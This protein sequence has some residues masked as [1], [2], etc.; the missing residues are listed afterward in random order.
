[1]QRI[2]TIL[3]FIITTTGFSQG[4]ITYK[5]ANTQ[6]YEAILN[7]DWDQ[8]ISL[9]KEA[10]ENGHDFFYLNLRLGIAF[11]RKA[12]Y[13]RAKASLREAYI[14][15]A[16]DTTLL[17]YSS[18]NSLALGESKL[19]EFYAEKISVEKKKLKSISVTGGLKKINIKE[20]GSN[21]YHLNL[22]GNLQLNA[23]LNSKINLTRITQKV[24]WGDYDQNQFSIKNCYQLSPKWNIE[25]NYIFIKMKGNLNYSDD[26]GMA[27]QK[28]TTSQ[29]S[30]TIYLGVGLNLNRSNVSGGLICQAL[31]NNVS[32]QLTNVNSNATFSSGT[33]SNTYLFQ[34][35]IGFQHYLEG[36]KDGIWISSQMSVPFSKDTLGF[37]WSNTVKFRF[38]KKSWFGVSHHF[39]SKINS[40]E[41]NGLIIQ[42]GDFL[43]N[44]IGA[45]WDYNIK[46]KTNFQLQILKENRTEFFE[47]IN[48]NYNTIFGTLT[49]KF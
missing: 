48:Y 17:Y 41:N 11:Y 37:S 30:N 36:N 45:S 49:F 1:M 25:L 24:I 14:Q 12:K 40:L 10:K 44:K 34:S 19:A 4:G 5:E 7:S 31:N 32:S 3:L 33:E 38:T 42:N 26:E 35:N 15:N 27:L 46:P 8:V 18:W 20:M 2:I 13:F 39:N 29:T 9:G 23:N 47:N 22:D 28:G 21:Q 16:R 43:Q 6:T